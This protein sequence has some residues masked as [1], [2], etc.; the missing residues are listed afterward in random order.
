[1][2]THQ[3]DRLILTSVR[4]EHAAELFKLH[5]DPLVQKA[6]YR[7][8]PQTTQ[9]VHKWIDWILAQWSK[10]GFCD[11]VV[12]EKVESGATFI[13]RSGLRD[14]KDTNDLEFAYAFFP[15][16]VGRGLG[17]EAARFTIAH[18]FQNSTKE[19]IVGFIEQG[20]TRADKA[21]KKF[22]LRYVDDRPYEGNIC[23]YY[24]ITREDFFSQP[25]RPI[26]G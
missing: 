9:D 14:C 2:T 20:N 11:W 7:N 19:K 17:P 23:R 16:A 1:M 8:V 15:N 18:G 24:E 13:G 22:G 21:A 6:I 5:N 10:N 26:G 3:T 25:L 4:H 12:Y